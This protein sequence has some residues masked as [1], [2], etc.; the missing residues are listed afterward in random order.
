M[1][2]LEGFR[3]RLRARRKELKMTQTQLGE[4]CGV[5]AQEI[6][7]FETG[8]RLPE[9][10]MLVKLC[11][12]L[13]TTP[14]NLLVDYINRRNVMY[15]TLL[16]PEVHKRVRNALHELNSLESYLPEK[17]EGEPEKRKARYVDG[18]MMYD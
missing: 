17:P 7:H 2:E 13:E 6:S 18:D 14:D 16:P 12:V 1:T 5:S 10:T 9:L 8:R 3:E 11:N 15:D 4:A